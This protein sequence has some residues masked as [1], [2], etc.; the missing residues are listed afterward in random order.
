VAEGFAVDLDALERAGQGAGSLMEELGQHRVSDL[1]CDGSVVGH[2]RLTDQLGSFCER[3]QVGIKAL[4]QDGHGLARNLQ[5]TVAAYRDNEQ[6]CEDVLR[7]ALGGG[8][9]RG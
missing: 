8:E 3:W 1:A 5:D 4:T 9:P 2:D 6:R 7:R